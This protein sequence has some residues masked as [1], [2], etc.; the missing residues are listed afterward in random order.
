MAFGVPKKLLIRFPNVDDDAMEQQTGLLW[1][2]SHSRLFAA[3]TTVCTHFNKHR[4]R[5]RPSTVT[6]RFS[7]LNDL[8]KCTLVFGGNS[9]I[10]T[11]RCFYAIRI[12]VGYG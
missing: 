3:E 12:Q 7:N 2:K 6:H 5:V 11:I 10:E 1:I 8:I 9:D 4:I